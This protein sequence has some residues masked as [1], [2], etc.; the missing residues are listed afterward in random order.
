MQCELSLLV[1]PVGVWGTRGTRKMCISEGFFVSYYVLSE[2]WE[3][4]KTHIGE[5]GVMGHSKTTWTR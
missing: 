3:P 5:I 4:L 1:R 2:G